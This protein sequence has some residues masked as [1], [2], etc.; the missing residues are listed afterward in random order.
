M[1]ANIFRLI[2]IL[3]CLGV[4]IWMAIKKENRDAKMAYIAAIT[5]CWMYLVQFVIKEMIK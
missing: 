3:F 2:L 4:Y 5:W 1:V